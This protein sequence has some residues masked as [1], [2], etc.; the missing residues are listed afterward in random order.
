[1]HFLG[2][3]VVVN[4]SLVQSYTGQ[5][6]VAPVKLKNT[7]HFARLRMEA[8]FPDQRGNP[9]RRQDFLSGHHQRS[10][11]SLRIWCGPGTARSACAAW[12]RWRR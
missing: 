3:P 1:M 10:G 12:I 9:E 11:R 6:R 2:W 7:A 5:I 4:E 8:A